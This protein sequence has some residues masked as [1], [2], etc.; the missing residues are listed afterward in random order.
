MVLKSVSIITF[1]GLAGGFAKQLTLPINEKNPQTPIRSS[2]ILGG[3]PFLACCLT[4]PA[5]PLHSRAS[6]PWETDPIHDPSYH[7]SDLY[8]DYGDNK[9]RSS[10]FGSVATVWPAKK[11]CSTARRFAYGAKVLRCEL[12]AGLR[13]SFF[14]QEAHRFFHR[15]A[16]NDRNVGRIMELTDYG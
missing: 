11:S 5:L 2:R 12:L 1:G 10:L 6:P 9:Q 7:H 8:W 13:S 3:T 4:S 16:G 15:R 14:L